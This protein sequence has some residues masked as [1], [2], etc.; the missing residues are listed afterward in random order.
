MSLR[1]DLW[2]RGRDHLELGV[3]W[4]CPLRQSQQ[5]PTLFASSEKNVQ[6]IKVVTNDSIGTC[7]SELYSFNLL[8]LPPPPRAAILVEYQTLLSVAPPIYPFCFFWQCSWI[9]G[10]SRNK[11]IECQQILAANRSKITSRVGSSMP[12]DSLKTLN[13]IQWDI[14]IA[15]NLY[16]PYCSKHWLSESSIF[17]VVL[18]PFLGNDRVLVSLGPATLWRWFGQRFYE[19]P[20]IPLWIA[21]LLMAQKHQTTKLQNHYGKSLPAAKWNVSL[22]FGHTYSSWDGFAKQSPVSNKN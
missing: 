22:T 8:K 18:D 2:Q 14:N 15:S 16:N 19:E 21:S 1:T 6:W 12:W 7:S 11:S 9:Y 17:Q 20:V 3:T 10:Q 5:I 13:P 4:S